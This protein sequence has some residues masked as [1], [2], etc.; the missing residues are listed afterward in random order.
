MGKDKKDNI[1]FIRVDSEM[2]EE[3]T[4]FAKKEYRTKSS[5]VKQAISDF[6]K[7]KRSKT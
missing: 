6:L 4:A 5:I 1:L 7:R 3:L 2:Y